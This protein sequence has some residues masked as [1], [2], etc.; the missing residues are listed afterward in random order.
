MCWLASGSF[1]QLD[2]RRLNLQ[3]KRVDG[4]RLVAVATLMR[5]ERELMTLPVLERPMLPRP[6]LE[7][8]RLSL[9]TVDNL[10]KDLRE[11]SLPPVPVPV[12]RSAVGSIHSSQ[13][14]ATMVLV[15]NFAEVKPRLRFPIVEGL[16]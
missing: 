15:E 3:V 13:R 12:V 8:E 10:S 14:L 5:L 9:V 6:M 4:C 16:G 7:R 1:A 2:L 11:K